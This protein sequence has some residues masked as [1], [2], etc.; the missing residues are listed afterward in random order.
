MENGLIGE[1]SEAIVRLSVLLAQEHIPAS[2]EAAI[3]HTILNL[4]RHIDETIRH[5]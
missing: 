4:L 3:V 1:S 5:D 2:V